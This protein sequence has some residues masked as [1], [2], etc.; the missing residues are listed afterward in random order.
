MIKHARV[1]EVGAKLP[2][3]I[4]PYKNIRLFVVYTNNKATWIAV[5]LTTIQNYSC[6]KEE[7]EIWAMN[8]QQ[9]NK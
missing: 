7:N 2:A 3:E 6:K 4:P 1:G 9:T 5:L 8:S